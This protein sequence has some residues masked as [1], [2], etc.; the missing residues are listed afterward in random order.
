MYQ[1]REIFLKVLY[2]VN[3]IQYVQS[4]H[5]FCSGFMYFNV[6]FSL[7]MQIDFV[8]Y[9]CVLFL[10]ILQFFFCY[11]TLKIFFSITY[12]FLLSVQLFA[13]RFFVFGTN[14]NHVVF[15]ISHTSPFTGFCLFCFFSLWVLFF[16]FCL[17]FFS[18]SS[19]SWNL[20][21]RLL[22]VQIYRLSITHFR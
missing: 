22:K 8:F 16:S 6:A 4:S 13:F 21:F 15:I 9:F 2:I 11:I 18:M 20:N 3:E 17:L 12:S 7:P 10:L 1:L 5:Y 14:I 19:F